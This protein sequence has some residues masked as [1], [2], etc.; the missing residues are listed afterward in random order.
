L[1]SFDP[2]PDIYIASRDGGNTNTLAILNSGDPPPPPADERS[3][4]KY[5]V[6]VKATNTQEQTQIKTLIPDAF[7]SSYQGSPVFQVGAYE[8]QAEADARLDLLS[9]A[10]LTGI[11]EVR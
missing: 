10:G 7:R 9:Q 8:S 3:R 6:V 5:R 11:I 4:L 2:D 1:G